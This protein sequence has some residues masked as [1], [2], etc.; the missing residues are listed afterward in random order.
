MTPP[1]EVAAFAKFR[2]KAPQG[3]FH[4]QSNFSFQKSHQANVEYGT[5]PL[6]AGK[7]P[8]AR[9]RR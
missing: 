3:G 7:G 4:Q 2:K 1:L 9:E 6:V 5:G 8:V